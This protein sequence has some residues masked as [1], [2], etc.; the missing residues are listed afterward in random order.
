MP[1]SD[2][3]W[4][5]MVR[6]GKALTR[7]FDGDG[8]IEQYGLQLEQVYR[9]PFMQ[10]VQPVADPTWTRAQID[11]PVTVAI[12]DAYRDLI[13]KHHVMPT[14]TASAELGMLPMFEAGRMGMH[15]ASAY[16]I[17]S[18]RKTPFDWDV[19]SLPW[20]VCNGKRYRG[21]GLWEE[22]FAILADTDVPE[23]AWKFARWCAS[24]EVV[25]WASREGH[26]VP[27][28]FDVAYSDAFLTPDMKPEHARMFLDSWDFATPVYQH[29][30]W[31]RI[32][33]DFEPILQQWMVGT[34]GR[35]I[36]TPDA[37]RR[38][39]RALQQ[40]LDDYRNEKQ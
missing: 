31:K 13:Y 1:T 6:M 38:L 17:E 30:W 16:A 28:R 33:V 40:V 24:P 35:K 21:T 11:H 20:F 4:D 14:P 3:T 29:P 15:A 7:D 8:V 34:D 27:A 36:S 19:V 23:E 22:E 39:D 5:D 2:W 18:F 37:M 12:M 10:Y 32:S 9:V 26:I 25:R